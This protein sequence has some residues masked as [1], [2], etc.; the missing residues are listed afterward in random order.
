MN[1]KYKEYAELRHNIATKFM[2]DWAAMGAQD[3]L[4]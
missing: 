4:Q 2:G 1:K 3:P